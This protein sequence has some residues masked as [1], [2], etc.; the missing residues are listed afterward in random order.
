MNTITTEGI[1]ICVTTQFRADLSS[2][3][4]NRFFYNYRIEMEN[5]NENTVQL[6][7]RDWYIFDSLHEPNFVSGK[8]VIG[9]QPI[10]RPGQT[11]SYTSGCELRSEIGRMKGFYTFLN[12][13]TGDLFQVFIPTF[14]LFHIGKLN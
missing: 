11:Y 13:S 4:D 9:E 5:N 6:M 8:G 12:K 10:L 14:D 2:V 3:A 7:H 1:K